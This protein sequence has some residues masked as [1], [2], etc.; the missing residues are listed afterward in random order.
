MGEIILALIVLAICFFQG[1]LDGEK[2]K[3]G[4]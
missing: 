2:C 1:Y 4:R 3:K